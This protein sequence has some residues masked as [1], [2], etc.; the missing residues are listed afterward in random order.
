MEKNIIKVIDMLDEVC[1]MTFVKTKLAIEKIN[2]GERIKIIYNSQEAKTNVPKSLDELNH[3][4]ISINDINKK[5]FYIIIE[6]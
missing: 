3:K 1:P 4:V 6:K 2:Q 5:Q